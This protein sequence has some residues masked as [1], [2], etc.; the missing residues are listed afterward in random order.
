MPIKIREE[1]IAEAVQYLE[2]KLSLVQTILD[3]SQEQVKTVEEKEIDLKRLEFFLQNKETQL[4]QIKQID[5]RLEPLIK[6]FRKNNM[7]DPRIDTL[8]QTLR[9]K[10]NDLL[11][12]ERHCYKN[13]L[14]RQTTV[15]EEL[16]NY[17]RK[18]SLSRI[19][20]PKTRISAKAKFFRGAL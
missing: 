14:R 6:E 3:H 2:K 18:K 15:R 12:I 17:Y 5:R 4:L 9:D 19:Y 20:M 7:R 11:S 1:M 8:I 16:T 10:L 13:L